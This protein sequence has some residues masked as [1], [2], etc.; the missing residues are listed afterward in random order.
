M[1]IKGEMPNINGRVLQGSI[2]D[3]MLFLFYI[4]DILINSSCNIKLFSDD[5]S[6]YFVVDNDYEAPDKTSG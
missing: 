4:N 5:N 1:V 2:F 6:I 3:S